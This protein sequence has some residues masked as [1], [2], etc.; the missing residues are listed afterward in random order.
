MTKCKQVF[1]GMLLGSMEEERPAT[2]AGEGWGAWQEWAAEFCA[3]GGQTTGSD[4]AWL[5]KLR[6]ATAV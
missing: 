2:K 3:R 5:R 6:R 1:A 4:S